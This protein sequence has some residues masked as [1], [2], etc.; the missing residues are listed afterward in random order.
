MKTPIILYLKFYVSGG[1][2]SPIDQVSFREQGIIA[3][4]EITRLL[5]LVI[6]QGKKKNMR[7]GFHLIL[8]SIANSKNSA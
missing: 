4:Q 8:V 3:L 6:E 2:S 5:E 7:I 1:I